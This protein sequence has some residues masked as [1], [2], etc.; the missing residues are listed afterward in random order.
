MTDPNPSTPRVKSVRLLLCATVCAA[1]PLAAAYATQVDP[2]SLRNDGWRPV[3]E[4][5]PGNGPCNYLYVDGNNNLLYYGTS[6]TCETR[7]NAHFAQMRSGYEIMQQMVSLTPGQQP[8]LLNNMVSWVIDTNGSGQSLNHA[9]SDSCLGM[10]STRSPITIWS[11]PL[12]SRANAAQVEACVLAQSVGYCNRQGAGTTRGSWIQFRSSIQ[13]CTAG[14]G[15]P[16]A[17]PSSPRRP[18]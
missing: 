10:V 4:R 16:A 3:M 17:R 12:S 1:I 2:T 11:L 8:G 18:S 6:G 5:A 9:S 13:A 7:I 14:L 15:R